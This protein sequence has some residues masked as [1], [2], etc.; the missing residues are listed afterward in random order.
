MGQIIAIANQK[1]GV[2]KTTTTINLGACVA[3]LGQRVL[4]VDIDPQANTTSGLGINK[5]ELQHSTYDMLIDEVPIS[6]A[7]MHTNMQGLDIVPSNMQLAGAEVELVNLMAREHILKGALSPA[8]SQ[9]D[10]ILIDCPPSLGLLTLNALT[11]SHSIIVPIQCEYFALEGLSQLVNTVELVKRH[12]NPSL[13]VKGVVLTMYDGRTNLSNQVVAE[14]QRFFKSKVYRTVIPRS[15][16]LG[17][18][19]SYGK[20][21]IEY[22][23]NSSASMAY[24][25]LARELVQTTETQQ[26]DKRHG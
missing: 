13:D 15:I 2:G 4:I 14:V 17:E 1:G 3:K 21:I 11:A 25:S 5:N 10:Y 20:S 12:L 23:P 22:A 19:P 8:Q 6:A 9:Y 18:A 26:E 7:L 24:Q 16:R